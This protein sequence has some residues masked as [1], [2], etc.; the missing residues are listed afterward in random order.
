MVKETSAQQL[1][2]ALALAVAPGGYGPA[3][4]AAQEYAGQLRRA[5]GTG[6]EALGSRERS[7][8]QGWGAG[9]SV[10]ERLY[11]A[12]LCASLLQLLPLVDMLA[13]HAGSRARPTTDGLRGRWWAFD[14]GELGR[15]TGLEG[16]IPAG[17]MEWLGDPP[18]AVIE[19]A[20]PALAAASRGTA[21][22]FLD[23][24][25]ELLTRLL[26]TVVRHDLGIHFTPGWAAQEVIRRALEGEAA[27]TVTDPTCGTGVFLLEALRALWTRAGE[28]TGG[29]A[30]RVAAGITGVE[31]S[32]LLAC[33]ARLG[34]LRATLVVAGQPPPAHA[35]PQ[36]QAADVLCELHGDRLGETPVAVADV[37][38]GNPPWVAWDA[39]PAG[40]KTR[41]AQ[42]PLQDY[43]LFD[44]RG[45]AARLGG[46]NDDLSVALTLVVLDRLLRPGGRLAFL[47]K[48][49][50]LTN[51]SARV[52]R[53]FQVV[54]AASETGERTV[55]FA[56]ERLCDLRE[57]NP[58]GA[59]VEPALLILRRDRAQGPTIP[60]E[61]W[62]KSRGTPLTVLRAPA[63]TPVDRSAPQ[64]PWAP[65][66]AAR[67]RTS[68][69]AGELP[70]KIR[71]GLK[72]DCNGVFLV[73]LLGKGDRAGLVAA[74][75]RPRTARRIRVPD[76]SGDLERRSVVPLIQSR[77]IRPLTLTG[78]SHAIVPSTAE[79]QPTEDTLRRDAP[80]TFAYLN[81]MREWLAARRSKV[82]ANPPFFRVFGVGPY[83]WAPSLVV[84]CGMS[85][86]PWFTVVDLVEDPLLGPMR[87]IPDSSCYLIPTQSHTEAYYLAGLLNSTP[88]REFLRSRSSGSKRGLSRA[89]VSRL[90]LPRYDPD[91]PPH[92]TLAAHAKALSRIGSAPPSDALLASALD[93]AARDVLV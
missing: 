76:W 62:R 10:T 36:V 54:A 12:E 13:G 32:P 60:S 5:W 11:C 73:E 80:A 69:L 26:P 65:R 38:V 28:P 9:R 21:D 77:H 82:F 1:A 66:S 22:P 61:R 46:A 93:P 71:H 30:W 50:L 39:L 75:N 19:A 37:L 88:V 41:L 31:T 34:L 27:R 48:L 43:R 47:L 16:L 63:Y 42:G 52:F 29:D 68:R 91:R 92:Q 45:F 44:L 64:G 81:S 4:I 23:R 18:A 57:A 2:R 59:A 86:R 83:N 67:A 24:A 89:V 3:R 72:H 84:W 56:V 17:L 8:A 74:R 85:L 33:C 40:Y 51:E 35:V 58:F 70:Y 79:G 6:D 49:N 87:P 15:R 53:A 7:V 20:Q 14:P 55:P 25:Q 90:G 78:W